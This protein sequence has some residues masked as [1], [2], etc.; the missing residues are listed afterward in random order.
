MLQALL[1]WAFLGLVVGVALWRGDRDAR[2]AAIICLLA[3]VGSLYQLSP[4]GS[5]ASPIHH[6]VALV[7]VVTLLMFL[8]VALRSDQFWPL[9]VTGLQLTTTLSHLLRML[10][11]SLLDVA[12]D[13]AM[14]LWSYPLLL[15]L[16]IAA[17]RNVAP[18]TNPS[19][20][21]AR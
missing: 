18:S 10:Y 17:W 16:G 8:R 12:Y 3:S 15:I 6:S 1:Y 11:P 7:D 2:T 9:W 5:V 19:G 13:A 14:Q 20:T 21:P 4:T